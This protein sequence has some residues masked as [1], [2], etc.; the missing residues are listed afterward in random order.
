MNISYQ[1]SKMTKKFYSEDHKVKKSKKQ[2]LFLLIPLLI[3]LA[4]FL[5]LLCTYSKFQM[6]VDNDCGFYSSENKYLT[7]NDNSLSVYDRSKNRT[8]IYTQNGDKRKDSFVVEYKDCEIYTAE[9][10][11]VI[12][13]DVGEENIKGET[14]NFV[15]SDDYIVYQI[16]ESILLIYDTK[17]KKTQE[18]KADVS[19]KIKWFDVNDKNIYLAS[20]Y[21]DECLGN[22]FSI[23]VYNLKT[24]EITQSLTYNISDNIRILRCGKDVFVISPP[25]GGIVIYRVDFSK[26][27]LE[28]LYTHPYVNNITANSKYII[29]SSEQYST[30]EL[31]TRTVDNENNGLWKY[32]IEEKKTVKL[33]EQCVFDDLL[34]T[35]NYVYGYTNEYV[36]PRGLANWWIKGSMITQIPINGN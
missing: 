19:N 12:K 13:T 10:G 8:R 31:I 23:K 16:N 36:L 15:V 4:C 22:I 27:K 6:S 25:K 17:T 18:I 3:I 26:Q 1:P 32:D 24:L 5:V 11:I 30:T 33:S 14:D 34:A 21:Y 7:Y 29:F 9:N 28:K 20:Y 35:D 2:F